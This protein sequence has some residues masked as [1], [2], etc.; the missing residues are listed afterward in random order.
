MIRSSTN[1]LCEVDGQILLSRRQNTGW[2]DGKLCLPGGHIEAGE[3][4]RQAAAREVQEELG[5]EI[6]EERFIFY[7][8][9]ARKS[10]AEYVAYEFKLSL[11]ANEEPINNEPE[12]CSELVR[13]D[14]NNLPKDVI[15][16]FRI[17]IEDGY[18]GREPYLEIGYV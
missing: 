17:I 11:E 16:D 8:V 12:L 5:L 9:A 2:E 6:P 1:V 3:T 15:E 14:P 13:V 4:P 10:T 18:L 7:C